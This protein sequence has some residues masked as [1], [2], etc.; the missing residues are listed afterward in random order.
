MINDG[1]L[2]TALQFELSGCQLVDPSAGGPEHSPVHNSQTVTL[3]FKV[4]RNLDQASSEDLSP[5]VVSIWWHSTMVDFMEDSKDATRDVCASCARF[6][7]TGICCFSAKSLLGEGVT[8]PTF[9]SLS[10]LGAFAADSAE[11]SSL[12]SW[13]CLTM[14]ATASPEAAANI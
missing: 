4:S 5:A 8:V 6:R 1:L 14:G 9:W 10:S 2:L 11:A 3:D 12:V 13:F 7:R